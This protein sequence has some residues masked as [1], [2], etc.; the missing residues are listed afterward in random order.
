MARNQDF[1]EGGGLEPQVIKFF[2][3]IKIWRRGEQIRAIQTCHRRGPGR[4]ATQTLWGLGAKP[5][6]A[7]RFHGK[8]LLF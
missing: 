7:G 5:P 4:F 1:V 8:K 6:V 3:Y 2:K